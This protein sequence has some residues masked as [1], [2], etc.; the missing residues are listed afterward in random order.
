MVIVG[1]AND[2]KSKIL[3]GIKIRGLLLNIVRVTSLELL[4]RHG[5]EIAQKIPALSNYSLV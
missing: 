5:H 2:E 3:R 4:Y 1:L